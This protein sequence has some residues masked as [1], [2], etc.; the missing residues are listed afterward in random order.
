[1]QKIGQNDYEKRLQLARSFIEILQQEENNRFLLMTGE[2]HFH[3]NSFVNIRNFRYWGVENPRILNEKELHPQR[4]TVWC[5]ILRDRIIGD[6]A[7]LKR[8]MISSAVS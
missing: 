8:D 6:N 2:A 1:M 5:A 3:L 7:S 4:V